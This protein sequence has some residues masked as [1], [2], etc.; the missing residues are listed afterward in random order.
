V[1][2]AAQNGILAAAFHR[3]SLLK[4]YFPEIFDWF[5][6]HDVPLHAGNYIH[7]YATY[8][9]MHGKEANRLLADRHVLV[10][11]RLNEQRMK[12]IRQGLHRQGADTV[13]FVPVSAHQA[14]LDDVELSA[15]ERPVDLALIAAGV[16][17]SNVLL[18]MKK[19]RIPQLDVG[20]C[21]DTLA[22]PELRWNRPFCVPDGEFDP[23][24]V[25]Y[26]S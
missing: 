5:D 12:N 7:M 8:A 1:R 3:S 23:A 16:G 14:M 15:V 25:E 26:V 11:T 6:E 21:I 20:Y 2:H 19:L 18:Q 13:Q 9:L 10:V 17:T 24:K 22:D 4:H